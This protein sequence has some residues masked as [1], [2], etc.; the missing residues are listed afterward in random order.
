MT[1]IWTEQY[2]VRVRELDEQHKKL[3]AMIQALNEAMGAGRGKQ[4]LSKIFANLMDYCVTHFTNEERIL[5]TQGYPE[6]EA[7]HQIHEKMMSKAR[8]LQNDFVAGKVGIT[9]E[10]MKFLEDWLGK[11]IMGT[12]KKYGAHLN[13]KGV[14]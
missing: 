3:F 5:K 9:L 4:E 1:L 11:H 12:D 14:S 8:S 7:H 6:Y 10:T 13:S 2:S